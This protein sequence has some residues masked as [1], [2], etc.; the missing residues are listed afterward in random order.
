MFALTST[1]SLSLH[2]RPS[3]SL[4]TRLDVMRSRRALAALDDAA[5][6]DLGLTRAQADREARRPIWDMTA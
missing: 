5:L 4:M 3:I 2:T 6:M 1:R